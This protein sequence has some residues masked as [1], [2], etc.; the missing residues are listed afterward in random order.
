M[1]TRRTLTVT[2]AATFNNFN[3]TLPTVTLASSVR[4]KPHA[5]S[6]STS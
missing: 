4:A 6:R 1:Y 5:R 3:R 2:C